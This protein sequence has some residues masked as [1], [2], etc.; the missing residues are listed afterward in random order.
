MRQRLAD[1]GMEADE[2][3]PDDDQRLRQTHNFAPS[4]H[5]LIYRANTSHSDEGHNE[6]AGEDGPADGEPSP[7]KAKLSQTASSASVDGRATQ[8]TKYKL[9]AAKWGL[10]PFWT[11]RPPDYGS[12]MKTINCRDDSLMENRGMWNTMKQKKRCIVVAESTLR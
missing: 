1:V 4:Y 2:T 12:Q 7:K 10:V 11:K 6:E 5:G 8:Q 3:P 9:Q